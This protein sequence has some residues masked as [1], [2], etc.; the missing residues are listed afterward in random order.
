MLKK[1][2]IPITL[3]ETTAQSAFK[4]GRRD[5]IYVKDIADAFVRAMKS[6]MTGK[7]EI[8]NIGCGKM[9]TMENVAKA[10]G[11]DIKFIP[12]RS[13]EVDAHQAN[14]KKT[15]KYL[16]WKPKTRVEPWLKEYCKF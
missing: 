3:T 11:G 16:K 10:I 2:K 12:K 6:K 1:K 9:T 13:F 4:T 14:M 8:L 7:G 5:F 15:F